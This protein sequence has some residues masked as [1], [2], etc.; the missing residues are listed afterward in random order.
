[1]RAWILLK[2]K[3]P[4]SF[5]RKVMKPVRKS[6]GRLNMGLL[7]KAG[8][9]YVIVRADV[10]D[11]DGWCNLVVPV[12]ARTETS[13]KEAIGALTKAAGS[14]LEVVTALRVREHHPTTPHRAHSFVTA[15]ELRRLRSKEL[16]PAGRHWPA[17]PGANPWG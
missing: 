9:D 2:V 10:V 16:I 6:L 14:E 17:S 8:T 5:V 13:L 4:K 12:D 11:S 1:V 15:S 3:D 7:S